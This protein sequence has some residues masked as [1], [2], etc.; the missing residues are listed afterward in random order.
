MNQKS[1]KVQEI[2]DAFNRCLFVC[3][4]GKIFHFEIL[5][6]LENQCTY[7]IFSFEA[8]SGH[9]KRDLRKALA[10]LRDT[11]RVLVRERENSSNQS[12]ICQLQE[13]LMD[14]EAAKLSALRGR[15]SLESELAETRAQVGTKID[16]LFHQKLPTFVVSAKLLSS[17]FFVIS[18]F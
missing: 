15:H 8:S 13:Q 14:A 1:W 18:Y 4:A 2:S 12:M 16:S 11:Q 6:V 3:F 9:Y 17:L 5:L 7:I 10:L